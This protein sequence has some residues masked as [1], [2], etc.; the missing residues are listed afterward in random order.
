MSHTTNASMLS[1]DIQCVT[2]SFS[3]YYIYFIRDISGNHSETLWIIILSIL[4]S[5]LDHYHIN[6]NIKCYSIF[7]VVFELLNNLIDTELM[8][9]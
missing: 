5:Y 8:K 4:S 1:I 7:L 3:Y 2:P 6:T 9:I